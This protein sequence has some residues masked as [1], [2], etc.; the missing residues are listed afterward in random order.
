MQDLVLFQLEVF[1]SAA[2]KIKNER[3]PSKIIM[4]LSYLTIFDR[5]D[6]DC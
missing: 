1:G 6:Y 4:C 5:K 3:M 2:H